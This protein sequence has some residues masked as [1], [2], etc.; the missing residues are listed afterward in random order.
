VQHD[1]PGQGVPALVVVSVG[2]GGEGRQ[3]LL[4]EI[5]GTGIR[6]Y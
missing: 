4:F 6:L 5:I 3:D 2:G 1:R